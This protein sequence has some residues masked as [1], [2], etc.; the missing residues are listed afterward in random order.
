MEGGGEGGRDCGRGGGGSVKKK[1]GVRGEKSAWV[2]QKEDM[3][4]TW[5]YWGEIE[6]EKVKENWS[7][8]AMYS[9]GVAA[10]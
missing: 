7:R 8:Q 2:D 6:T 4:A 9:I 1:R 3:V 5:F 10:S